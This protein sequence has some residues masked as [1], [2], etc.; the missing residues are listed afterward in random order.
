MILIGLL[1]VFLFLFI[2]IKVFL[3]ILYRYFLWFK[4]V[5]YIFQEK[6]VFFL[7]G[8]LYKSS[9]YFKS[10]RLLVDQKI[11]LNSFSARL[12][13]VKKVIEYWVQFSSNSFI[14]TSFDRINLAINLKNY[15]QFSLSGISLTHFLKH[16]GMSY[17]SSFIGFYD[18]CL[19]FLISFSLYPVL[20]STKDRF[21]YKFRP[22]TE[23]DD[24]LFSL[25]SSFFGK[26]G[27]NF[28]LFSEIDLLTFSDL[29]NNF[30]NLNLFPINRLQ[31]NNW[32][33]FCSISQ[34]RGYVPCLFYN[35]IDLLFNGLVRFSF[36]S[37][38]AYL[39][40]S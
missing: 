30:F 35:F 22:Y 8:K 14:F 7:Q 2:Y 32:I 10:R 21:Q 39:F 26:P 15:Q 9:S 23:S 20:E 27:I 13:A 19:D 16:S 37:Y 1:F 38:Y 5:L 31:L 24:F 40:V 36:E 4:K 28:L 17:N 6:R 18:M 29:Q 11:F 3:F 34:L 33:E 12:Y 25:P